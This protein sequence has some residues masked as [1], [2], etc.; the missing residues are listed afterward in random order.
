MLRDWAFGEDVFGHFGRLQNLVISTP[1]GWCLT[2]LPNLN[3]L[4]T[5]VLITAEVENHLMSYSW[6][7]RSHSKHSFEEFGLLYLRGCY[8]SV[9][10]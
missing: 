6:S 7:C 3:L 1:N 8:E 10:G 5:L 9:L 2:Q 4:F